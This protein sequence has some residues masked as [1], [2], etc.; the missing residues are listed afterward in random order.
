[1]TEYDLVAIGGGAGG[2]A[3]VRAVAVAGKRAALVTDSPIG[4]DCTWTGCVPSK[5]L[6]AA[7]SQG[8]SFADAMARVREAVLHIAGTE[9]AGVLQ[10]EGIDVI[11]G[12]AVL[13]TTGGVEVGGRTL[14]AKA[15]VVATGGGPAVP[16]IPGLRQLAY[17]TNEDVW[18]LDAAPGRLG[19]MGGGPIGCEFAQ[20]MAR[21]GVEVTLFEMADRLLLKEEPEASEVVQRALEADGVRVLTGTAVTSVR[22]VGVDGGAVVRAG[23]HEVGVDKLLVAVGRQPNTADMGLAEAGVE[24]TDRG[25]IEV[26]ERLRTSATGIY[27]VGDVNGLLPFTHAANEQ[28]M[29]V[30]RAAAGVRMTWKFDSGRVP[31]ATFTS[32]EVA[33]VGV[34]EAD[35]PRGSRVAYLPMAENDRAIAEGRTAGFVKLIAAPRP[36]LRNV[37]AGRIVGATIVAERG[38]EMIHG[39]AQAM[40][41]RSFTGRLAQL[42]YAYPTWSFGVQK[43]AGQFFQAIEGRTARPAKRG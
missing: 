14:R 42:P 17:L 35:A 12:R 41:T 9:D 40:L 34:A 30:G 5:T 37:G 19:V 8:S 32:P 31:W 23:K 2:L 10:R 13:D 36:F 3:A 6:I 15:V 27:A 16:P 25:F 20:A 33:R 22:A 21:L 4:G 11:E 29:L 18:G 38:G 1:V 43:C 28:G 26:D 39:P 7:A 24:L